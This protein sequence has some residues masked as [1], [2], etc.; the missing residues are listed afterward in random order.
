MNSDEAVPKILDSASAK[1]EALDKVSYVDDEATFRFL[2]NE[3]AMATEK[4]AQGIRAFGADCVTLLNQ[5]E[6]R[7][8]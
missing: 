6:A 7:F 1:A 8:K 2:F 4:L 3:D 5:L